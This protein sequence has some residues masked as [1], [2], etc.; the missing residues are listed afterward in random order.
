[1]PIRLCVEAKCGSPVAYRGRCVA[2]ARLRDKATHPNKR[3]YNSNRWKYARRNQLHLE[4]LCAV[5]G[6]IA[7]DVDHKT[8][9]E[10]GGA[11]WAPENLASLC[12]VCHGR[13]TKREQLQAS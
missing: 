2:H 13:K 11:V 1:M 10:W 7:T 6:C 8:P 3:I 9:I 5:C 4:P 12:A